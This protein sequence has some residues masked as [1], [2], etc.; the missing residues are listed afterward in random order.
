MII[1]FL[2]TQ[3]LTNSFNRHHMT[4]IFGHVSKMTMVDTHKQEW[5][6][7]HH[8]TKNGQKAMVELLVKGGANVHA[9]NNVRLLFLS[10]C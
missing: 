1:L 10:I 4:M 7:L 5:T 9:Q 6:P 8:A 3:L 2:L